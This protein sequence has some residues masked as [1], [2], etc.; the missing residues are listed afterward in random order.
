[1]HPSR[2]FLVIVLLLVSILLATCGSDN[3]FTAPGGVVDNTLVGTWRATRAEF[4]SVASPGVRAEIVSLGATLVISLDAA[5]GYTRTITD[6]GQRPD[7]QTGTW[8][9]TSDVLTLRPSGVTFTIEFDFTL[10][11]STLSVSGGHVEFDF[12]GDEVPDEAVLSASFG[13]Q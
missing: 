3:S 12:N 2:A 4:V 8:S 9:A 13:R 10:N 5:G 11:G 7:V 1:M 6:P